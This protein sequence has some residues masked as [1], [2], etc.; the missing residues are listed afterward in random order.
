MT[1]KLVM[2]GQKLRG[3]TIDVV[4]VY[5]EILRYDSRIGFAELVFLFLRRLA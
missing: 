3:M 1:W 2:L 4:L 5:N